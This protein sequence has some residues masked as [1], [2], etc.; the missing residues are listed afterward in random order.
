MAPN[1][2]IVIINSMQHKLW[3]NLAKKPIADNQM[4]IE[5]P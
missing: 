5:N 3:Q 1:Y 4:D 2:Y